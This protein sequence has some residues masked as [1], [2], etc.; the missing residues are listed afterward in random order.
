[1]SMSL[2]VENVSKW[3]STERSPLRRLAVAAG[4]RPRG[5]GLWALRDATLA[6]RRG[7]CV[8]LVGGNGSGKSTLLR[9]LAGVAAPTSGRAETRGRVASILELGSFLGREETGRE[10]AEVGAR[11][12]GFARREIPGLLDG[13]REFSGL[14]DAFDRR[15]RTYSGG[16]ALR[17]AFSL[18]TCRRPDVLLLDE[19][20]AVGDAAFQARCLERLEGFLAE[21]TAIVLASHDLAVATRFASRAVWLAAGRVAADGDPAEVVETYLAS[22]KLLGPAATGP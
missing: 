17:L 6:V 11:L 3:Y 2:R 7:E 18:A 16:Q 21:G 9:I 8:A 12:L 4:G 10:N 22:A 1:M 19:V 5:E 14:G 15:A 20:L 13:V